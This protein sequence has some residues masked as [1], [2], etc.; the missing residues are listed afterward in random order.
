VNTDLTDT[1]VKL[2]NANRGSKP[3]T[4]AGTAK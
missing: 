2:F 3:V 1:V 4:G